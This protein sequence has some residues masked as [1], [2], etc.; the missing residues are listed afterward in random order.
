MPYYKY[1]ESYIWE[2]G[3]KGP[4]KSHKIIKIKAKT[5]LRARRKLP[6]EDLGRR[7]L[8]ILEE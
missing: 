3:D 7:W 6:K 2:G 1:Q 8:L 5:E 4:D